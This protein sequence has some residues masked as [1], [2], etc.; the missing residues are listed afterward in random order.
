VE[1]RIFIFCR[2]LSAA[3]AGQFQTAKSRYC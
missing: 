1:T 3:Y 2:M